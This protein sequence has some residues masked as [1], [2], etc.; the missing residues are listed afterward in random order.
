VGTG[1]LMAGAVLTPGP[2]DDLALA[3]GATGY[4]AK[5]V[6]AGEAGAYG[7]LRARSVPGDVLTPHH[8]PQAA[9]EFTTRAEG[10]A[11]VLPHS[12]H[13]L[14]RTFGGRGAATLRAE[15]GMSFR[16]V[17][18]RDMRDIRQLFGPKYDQGLRD[19][20]QYY[21]QNFPELIAK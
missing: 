12:E 19:L 6:T 2:Q 14:T 3:A 10:G 20:L 11:L 4:A 21:K 9:M 17:L 18:A 13:V 8:M 1:I 5:G 16:P 15:Q 7:V